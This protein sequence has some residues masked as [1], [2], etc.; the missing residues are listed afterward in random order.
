MV[1]YMYITMSLQLGANDLC[2][3][4]WL[5]CSTTLLQVAGTSVTNVE[6]GL[7]STETSP[8]TTLKFGFGLNL[9][10]HGGVVGFFQRM[11]EQKL[12]HG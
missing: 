8:L 4:V 2:R 10:T 6:F 12:V 11:V 5:H 7:V 9:T 3:T 1:T